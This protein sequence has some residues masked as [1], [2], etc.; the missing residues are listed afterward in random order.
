[1]LCVLHNRCG[2]SSRIIH[3]SLM[4]ELVLEG[5]AGAIDLHVTSLRGCNMLTK[6]ADW[7]FSQSRF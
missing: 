3:A 4:Q 1:M 7:S 5:Y 2:A 6:C